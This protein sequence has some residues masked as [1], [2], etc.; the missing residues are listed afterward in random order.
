MTRLSR[1]LRLWPPPN[2]FPYERVRQ[3]SFNDPWASESGVR[4]VAS[5][6]SVSIREGV[7]QELP[8][9]M[10]RL[11]WGYLLWALPHLSPCERVRRR[12]FLD[13]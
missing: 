2:L 8:E 10:A 3:S 5:P 6:R 9:V 1:G 12:S 7:P 13:P 4:P 11:I